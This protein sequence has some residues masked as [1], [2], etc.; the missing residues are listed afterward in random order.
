MLLH[1][2]SVNLPER[3]GHMNV[4]HLFNNPFSPVKQSS[5]AF[6]LYLSI[7]IADFAE[8]SRLSICSAVL[9][10]LPITVC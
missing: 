3:V 10:N 4:V 2:S 9:S 5:P 8:T 6:L 7:Y 1:S